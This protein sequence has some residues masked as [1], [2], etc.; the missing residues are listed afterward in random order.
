VSQGV[1]DKQ[2]D[3]FTYSKGIRKVWGSSLPCA[4]HAADQRGRNNIFTMRWHPHGEANDSERT[5]ATGRRLDA[6][7]QRRVGRAL[8]WKTSV[9][10][11]HPTAQW[12]PQRKTTTTASISAELDLVV[13]NTLNQGQRPPTSTLLQGYARQI[14]PKINEITLPN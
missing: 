6:E 3:Y 13:A 2:Q 14:Q 7:P 11:Q 9:P 10:S 12:K 4:P 1:Y 5:T 8:P